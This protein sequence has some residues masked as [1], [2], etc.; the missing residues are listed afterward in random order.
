VKPQ[1]NSALLFQTCDSSFHGL[2]QLIQCP[3]ERSRN[4]LAVY[5]VTQPRDGVTLRPKAKFF[6]NPSERDDERLRKLLE[7]RAQRRITK[8]DLQDIYPDWEKKF[9]WED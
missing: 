2:P 3:K 7:I 4:S 6:S 1:F 9:Y 5:Y 8:E